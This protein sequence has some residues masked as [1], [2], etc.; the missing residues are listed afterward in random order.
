LGSQLWGLGNFKIWF[1]GHGFQDLGSQLWGLDFHTRGFEDRNLKN[2]RTWF[3]GCEISTFGTWISHR[4]LHSGLRPRAPTSHGHPLVR[5]NGTS[6]SLLGPGVEVG[7]TPNCMKG[8]HIFP[9]LIVG[10]FFKF[11]LPS[12]LDLQCMVIVKKEQNKFF[13]Q[14][15]KKLM[16]NKYNKQY[17]VMSPQ[18]YLPSP[19][20]YKWKCAKKLSNF[21]FKFWW[22]LS[23]KSGNMWQNIQV[24]DRSTTT[25]FF[26]VFT[27][28]RKI[29]QANKTSP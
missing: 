29:R 3:S 12:K 20:K 16:F 2:F 27:Y 22:S 23:Q 13:F 28:P 25:F 4:G 5:Y 15:L 18:A 19:L 17:K 11:F 7:L 21:I 6:W 26:Q 1:L 8:I 24:I 10:S 9:L 14:F